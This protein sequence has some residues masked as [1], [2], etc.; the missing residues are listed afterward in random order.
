MAIFRGLAGLAVSHLFRPDSRDFVRRLGT[1]I[2]SGILLLLP[3]VVCFG[4]SW[5]F[6]PSYFSHQESGERVAQYAPPAPSV[7]PYAP[8]YVV[9]GYRHTKSTI[10]SAESYD[11]LHIV[12][13]WGLGA[14]I[15]PYEE[16]E[17][18]FREGATPFGP[19]GN[20]QGPWTLPFQ[21]WV[22]PFALGRLPYP[23]WWIYP[24]YWYQPPQ[25]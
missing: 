25:P 18:P 10:R 20:P 24:P 19:W 6:Q 5:V 11:H 14:Y 16:W 21:S 23:P 3:G 8:N 9:S 15:R 2:L 4:E 22:N 17:Y 7:A 12:K 13:T 1:S